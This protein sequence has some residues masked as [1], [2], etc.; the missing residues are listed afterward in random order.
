MVPG[1]LLPFFGE[2]SAITTLVRLPSVDCSGAE[3]VVF[4]P[5][6]FVAVRSL[7]GFF[8]DATD[9]E[10]LSPSDLW[11]LTSDLCVLV[12]VF[13]DASD[14]GVFVPFWLGAFT[15]A[16]LVPL[17]SAS[18]GREGSAGMTSAFVGF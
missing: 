3:S 14:A 7:T 1:A 9:R 12:P 10:L 2:A 5:T 13:A 18:G 6:A 15:G 8:S 16:A 11:P 4:F 17:P